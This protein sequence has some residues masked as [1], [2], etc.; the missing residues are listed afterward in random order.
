MNF[1]SSMSHG[2]FVL[3]SENEPSFPD[4]LNN[5]PLLWRP[6]DLVP[7][8]LLMEILML[9]TLKIFISYKGQYLTI[10]VESLV[11]PLNGQV[12]RCPVVVLSGSRVEPWASISPPAV[13]GWDLQRV[14]TWTASF[15]YLGPIHVIWL[16]FLINQSHVMPNLLQDIAGRNI[17]GVSDWGY[18]WKVT[19]FKSPQRFGSHLSTAKMFLGQSRDPWE[20]D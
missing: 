6:L 12:K 10:D 15:L 13:Q 20:D 17:Q 19:R 7:V 3:V 4:N 9:G 5:N 11:S 2:R 8:L 18:F 16:S 14:G 1:P